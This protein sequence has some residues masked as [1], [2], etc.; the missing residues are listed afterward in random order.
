MDP[1]QDLATPIF[2]IFVKSQKIGKSLKETK[3]G[4]IGVY[5]NS[6]WS[7]KS[8]AGGYKPLK[9]ILIKIRPRPF[10]FALNNKKLAYLYETKCGMSG[11]Y[12]DSF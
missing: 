3:S 6:F 4:M 7:H 12:G 10:S 5:N 2:F 8:I 1:F 11:V 9:W